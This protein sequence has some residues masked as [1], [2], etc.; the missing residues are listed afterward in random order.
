MKGDNRG[1]KAGE[2]LTHV[3]GASAGKEEL[4]AVIRRQTISALAR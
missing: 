3:K 2:P 1:V 4:L